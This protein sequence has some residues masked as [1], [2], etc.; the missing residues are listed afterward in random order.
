MFITFVIDTSGSMSQK[1]ANGMTLLDCCKV[2]I[3]HFI[4]IRSKDSSM[5][6]DKFFLIT[7][8]EYVIVNQS[9]PTSPPNSSGNLVMAPCVKVGWKESFNVFLQEVKNLNAKDMSNLSYSIQKAFDLLNQF[10]IQSSIDNYGQGRIPWYIDPGVIILISD[11]GSLSTFNNIMDTF[12]QPRNQSFPDLSNEPFR[13]DQRMFSMLLRFGSINTN[14]NQS[15]MDQQQQ[16]NIFSSIGTVCES[17]GGKCQIVNSVKS[18]IQTIESIVSKLHHGVIVSFEPINTVASPP[19]TSPTTLV[20]SPTITSSQSSL[21][22]MI[23]VIKNTTY[24]WPIPES[25]YPD[26]SSG[27]LPLRSA[28]PMIRYALTECDPYIP[29][30]FPHDKY[31]I[32]SC[33]MTQTI[34]S[35]K[36][37]S[38]QVFIQNSQQLQGQGEAFGMV[39]VSG[40]I[41]HLYVLPYN[42]TKMFQLID[43]LTGPLKSIPSQKWRQDFEN[44][45]QSIPP[46]Y[47]S[48]MRNAFKR[49]FPTLSLVSDNIDIQF[50]NYITNIV[51]KLKAQ[52]PPHPQS[53]STSS[54]TPPTISGKLSNSGGNLPSQSLESTVNT[55][56]SPKKAFSSATSN[57]GFKNFH[58][59]LEFG[60][61]SPY[62]AGGDDDSLSSAGGEYPGMD[63]DLNSSSATSSGTSGSTSLFNILNRNV[64][65]IQR[66]NLLSQLD[67][68]RDHIFKRKFDED[69]AK[70]HLPISQM[71]NFHETIAKK[72][73][74]RDIDDEKKPNLPLFGN[75]YRK[76]KGPRFNAMSI[77]EADIS[78]LQQNLPQGSMLDE[79]TK[80]SIQKR[81][82]ILSTKQQQQQH[83]QEKQAQLQQQ[84]QQQTPS[85]ISNSNSNIPVVVPQAVPIPV[86]QPISKDITSQIPNV[87]P[88][89]TTSASE[90]PK[91]TN[92]SA[93]VSVMPVS[94]VKVESGS[95]MEIDEQKP[96]NQQTQQDL[97]EMTNNS[98]QIS[99]HNM[100]ISKFVNREIRKPTKTNYDLI[101]E[102][103]NQLH[104]DNQSKLLVFLES[105][106]L[107]KSYK[108]SVLV[109][110]LNSICMEILGEEPPNLL[111]NSIVKSPVSV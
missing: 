99:Q 57:F 24:Y 91:V 37:T 8:E 50:L 31:E 28:H 110:K 13:W 34:I 4:K 26:L 17:T 88:T 56:K 90:L 6:N 10:R 66:T 46:Y 22:K 98:I 25:Y 36:L 62:G 3:E 96:V 108:K 93:S 104:G 82:R 49:Y 75:P 78:E 70:H 33:N 59:I 53:L 43:E 87:I 41:V 58:Q 11:G 30:N 69:D 9:N 94:Q 27:V 60:S 109:L 64:F 32:E 55:T 44:Y 101:M 79:I 20:Q 45:C 1:C 51:K 38:V 81:R 54:I 15:T 71:G 73:S 103:L 76:E 2:A 89:S 106:N 72:E 85:A 95:N 92:V 19:P 61:G 100:E 48:P 16:S 105:L 29:E 67:R 40:N 14:S 18:M 21:H 86:N 52:Q 42:Y 39:K 107:A 35:M 63:V 23:Y 102:K 65:D 74:L 111:P 68:M 77:D 84:Q 97:I 47:I 12:T 80:K 83:Q 5:R 7:S